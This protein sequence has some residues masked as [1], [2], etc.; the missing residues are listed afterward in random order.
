MLD[1]QGNERSQF[2]QLER[3]RILADRSCIMAQSIKIFVLHVNS[4]SKAIVPEEIL[5]ISR[6]SL[7]KLNI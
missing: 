5:I 6:T 3:M 7:L 2:E 1:G 4:Y